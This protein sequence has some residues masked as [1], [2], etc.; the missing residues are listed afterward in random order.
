MAEE[1]S[2]GRQGS[3]RAAPG[4]TARCCGD[5]H[6]TNAPRAETACPRWAVAAWRLRQQEHNFRHRH[7][8]P[9]NRS[10]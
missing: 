2:A 9:L 7:S 6:A 3:N 1:R 4:L 5:K 10:Q 8:R